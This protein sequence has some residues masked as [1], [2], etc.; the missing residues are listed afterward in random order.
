M[1]YLLTLL[2]LL[3]LSGKAQDT[4]FHQRGKNLYMTTRR[5]TALIVS[6][7]VYEQHYDYN[8]DNHIRESR[9]LVAFDAALLALFFGVRALMNK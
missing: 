1:K 5:G 4:T 9:R 2:L 3:S 6:Q 7:E 8:R